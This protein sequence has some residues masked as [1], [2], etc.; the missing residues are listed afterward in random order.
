MLKQW[1]YYAPCLRFIRGEWRRG[2]RGKSKKEKRRKNFRSWGIDTKKDRH[3][4]QRL[5]KGYKTRSKTRIKG[6]ERMYWRRKWISGENGRKWMRGERRHT[7]KTATLVITGTMRHL[8]DRQVGWMTQAGQRETHSPS[9][10]ILLS[11]AQTF[12]GTWSSWF[13]L[14]ASHSLSLCGFQHS[15][16]LLPLV[17]LLL[18]TLLSSHLSSATSPPVLWCFLFFKLTFPF[19][20]VFWYPLFVTPI[21][22][23]SQNNIAF[24]NL[25]GH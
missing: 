1:L 24:Q 7:S 18:P 21:L 16:L 6:E 11:L 14:L 17:L 15:G 13:T 10:F 22:Y 9:C 23:V 5:K 8:S 12:P 25:L 4:R 20:S 3:I 19:F 2:G